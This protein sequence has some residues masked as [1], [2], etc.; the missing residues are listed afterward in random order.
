MHCL[1]I[2][3]PFFRQSRTF[4]ASLV[5]LPP[6]A[7][8]APDQKRWLTAKTPRHWSGFLRRFAAASAHC[9]RN[10]LWFSSKTR[11]H[12]I[13]VCQT[14]NPCENAMLYECGKSFSH[15]Y[16]A[17]NFHKDHVRHALMELSLKVFKKD[18]CTFFVSLFCILCLKTRIW[19]SISRS[20]TECTIEI[21]V[22]GI[23]FTK[24][25]TWKPEE[26]VKR[27][28]FGSKRTLH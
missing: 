15:I 7:W 20:D 11:L 21:W 9:D 27:S 16:K 23:C 28:K 26:I 1:A 4:L 12:Y 13:R 18:F 19:V 25:F 14:Y 3:S 6:V 10:G 2:L 22:I 8:F 17:Y 24:Y 5:G